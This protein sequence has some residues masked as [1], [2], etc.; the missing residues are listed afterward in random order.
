MDMEQK[1]LITELTRGKDLAK[2]LSNN[3]NPSSSSL[4]THQHLI[5]KIISSYEKALSML[6]CDASLK[7][8]T[9]PRTEVSYQPCKDINKKR[10]TMPQRTEH[11]KVGWTPEDGYCWRKY[12][13]KDILG[14]NFPR[15][16]YR[17]THRHAQGCLAT[18]QV[19]KSDSDPTIFE[20]T[21]RGRHTCNQNS[22]LALASNSSKDNKIGKELHV[23][24]EESIIFPSFSFAH[25]SIGLEIMEDDLFLDMGSFSPSFR[26]PA[27]SESNY[28]S[29]SPCHMMNEFG[30][31]QSHNVQAPESELTADIISTPTSVNNSPFGDFDFSLAKE[32]LD[33]NFLFDYLDTCS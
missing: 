11:V 24:T 7:P 20:V 15:A 31:G 32:D 13:Q 17:C 19:Q 6:H 9:T 18:K 28:L 22:H 5:Q 23:K 27:T 29:K 25:E 4:E 8:N 2:Q 26:S 21:Y 12:G 33:T 30:H 3:L 10:K 14:A 1:I 16:Y